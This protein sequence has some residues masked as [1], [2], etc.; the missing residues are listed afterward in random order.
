MGGSMFQKHEKQIFST[1]IQLKTSS[2]YACPNNLLISWIPPPPPTPPLP[3]SPSPPQPLSET[4]KVQ[5]SFEYNFFIWAQ[6]W[7]DKTYNYNLYIENT[8]KGNPESS[9][10]RKVA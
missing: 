2:Q 1:N 6:F 8:K 7:T 5:F 10:I 3:P 9:P 4:E